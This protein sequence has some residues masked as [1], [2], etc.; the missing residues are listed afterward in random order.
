MIYK[1]FDKTFLKRYLHKIQK[2]KHLEK[3]RDNIR[4]KNGLKGID[5]SKEKNISNRKK[6]SEQENLVLQLE[7]IN[8][9]IQNIKTN[10]SPIQKD[11]LKQINAID[12]LSGNWKCAEILRMVY[13]DGLSTKEVVLSIYGEYNETNRKEIQRLRNV[14]ENK[15][16]KPFITCVEY[17][18]KA[19]K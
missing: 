8:K 15:L 17:S 12:S 14:T 3:M 4:N 1:T 9:Q 7:K 19:W 16:S 11:L 18:L 13:I 6:N 2:L 5:Y 10:I